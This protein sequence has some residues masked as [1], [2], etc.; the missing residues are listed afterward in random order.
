MDKEKLTQTTLFFPLAIS[1]MVPLA[2]RSLYLSIYS[3]LLLINQFLSINQSINQSIVN[4]HKP[5]SS[6]LREQNIIQQGIHN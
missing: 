2:L 6:Q 5:K 3:Y 1:E 4:S